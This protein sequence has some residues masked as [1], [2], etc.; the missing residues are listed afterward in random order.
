MCV[1]ASVA[2]SAAFVLGAPWALGRGGADTGGVLAARLLV[3]SGPAALLAALCVFAP[4]N[5][6]G[7]A[8]ALWA[9]VLGTGAFWLFYWMVTLRDAAADTGGGANI[10]LGLLML[11]SPV[12]VFV[13]MSVAY[14]TG[15]HASRT[16]SG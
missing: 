9:A 13:A 1:A 10:G 6:R 14:A 8:R 2:L 16:R 12:V 15:V 5:R 3:C 4:L 7:A 11:A